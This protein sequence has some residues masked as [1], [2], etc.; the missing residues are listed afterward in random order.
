MAGGGMGPISN[1]KTYPGEVTLYVIVACII[2]ASGGAL[3][4]YDNGITGGVISMPGFL[5]QFFPDLLDTSSSHGDNQ[6]PYC[7]YDSQVLE[8]FTSSLFI[9]GVF[10]ALPAGYTTRHWG[11]KR[12]ML[13]AGLLF[14]VGVVL[15]AGAMDIA[16]LLCGRVLLGIA[17]AFASVSVTLYNSEMAPAHLRGRL[18]QVFQVI[19]TLGVVLAQIINVWTGRFQPWGWRV[20]LG[21]A[22][23]PA[24]VLTLGGIFLP[25]TPNS[26][27]ERG[28]EEEGYKVLQRIR[29]IRDVDEEFDDIRAACIQANAITNP[30]REILKRKSRPQLFVAM[31]STFFQQWTGINTVIFY[32]PQLFISL[33]TGRKAALLATILKGVVNHFATYVSLWAAD[34]FGRRILFLEGGVQMLLSLVGIGMTLVLAGAQPNAAWIALFFMCFYICA[35]A[36]SWGP[37]PWLYAAEVQFLETRSAGQSIATLINLL[38][39]FVIGQ[40]Y[41][42]MLCV[43]KWGIFIFFAGMV[44]IMTIVVAAFYPETKGLPIE[45]APHVFADHWFWKRY[46]PPAPWSEDEEKE[47]MRRAILQG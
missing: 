9:A 45:E 7:K 12:T 43:F 5:E 16:M 35:Y 27:I 2:A 32:A 39:S 18:N 21:L 47:N 24:L 25:D 26:L 4:G 28:Y 6:D 46:A 40:T 19:L 30:W 14:D 44:L 13:L 31:T 38:F 36:W 3:F 37:L 11:R 33:G 15:T 8:W 42:S 29:G 1:G 41:L 20:S 17:V 34:S 23:V 22:G 10:A